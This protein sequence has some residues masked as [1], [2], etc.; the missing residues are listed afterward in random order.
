MNRALRVHAPRI[1]EH[2]S[3]NSVG[4]SRLDLRAHFGGRVVR[5]AEREV[6]VPRSERCRAGNSRGATVRVL[7]SV[8]DRLVRMRVR[9]ADAV[10]AG[11]VVRRIHHWQHDVDGVD[12]LL[13]LLSDPHVRRVRG[14]ETED[15]GR[16]RNAERPESRARGEELLANHLRAQ[17][18]ARERKGRLGDESLVIRESNVVELNFAE[19][20]VDGFAREFGGVAPGAVLVRVEPR[21]PLLVAPRG[22]WIGLPTNRPL[23]LRAR[24]QRILRDDDA[25]DRIDVVRAHRVEHRAQPR[26]GHRAIGVRAD[27]LRERHARAVE[28]EAAIVLH[29]DHER[30]DLGA[31]RERDEL[32]AA[33]AERRPAIHVEPANDFGLR[34]ERG[35]ELGERV[36]RRDARGRGAEGWLRHGGRWWRD[37]ALRSLR[38]GCGNGGEDKR[39]ESGDADAGEHATIYV[40]SSAIAPAAHASGVHISRPL[41]IHV[42]RDNF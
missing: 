2:P 26:M 38:A 3:L 27:R 24:E 35:A 29:V 34:N 10:R 15:I 36:G 16:H 21:I 41:A 12:E 37:G 8:R 20:E 6:L 42:S 40:A 33:I 28:D 4:V 9:I 31:A 13:P 17:A 1:P 11:I 23:E 19:T 39:R 14:R 18:S 7:Q 32:P 30:V 25:R 5:R 22:T